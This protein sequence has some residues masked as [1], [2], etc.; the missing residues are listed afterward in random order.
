ML[1]VNAGWC[2]FGFA[3]GK[4]FGKRTD[5]PMWTLNAGLIKLQLISDKGLH[6]FREAVQGL[7]EDPECL[8]EN[9]RGFVDAVGWRIARDLN[10]ADDQ[11]EAS[12]KI[13]NKAEQENMRL[14]TEIHTLKRAIEIV[15]TPDATHP[16]D[17]GGDYA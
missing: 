3:K 17:S 12:R 15:Q 1:M 8:N 14:R 7:S 2:G 16:I 6:L 10:R 4:L 13:A 11:V 9:R 5:V